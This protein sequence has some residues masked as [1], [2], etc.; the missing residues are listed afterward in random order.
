[1]PLVGGLPLRPDLRSCYHSSTIVEYLN[2]LCFQDQSK[3]LAYWYFDFNNFAQQD[4]ESMLRSLI[5]QLSAGVDSFPD[6]VRRLAQM[7]RRRGSHPKT[8]QLLLTFNSVVTSLKKDVFLVLDALDEFP[9]D[10]RSLKRSLLLSVIN[11]I[12]EAGHSNLH[13]LVTSRPESDIR[14]RL[15][16][17]SNPPQELNVESPLLVDLELF[18]DTTMELSPAL[19]SLGG[20]TK[21][22]IRNHLIT[23]EQR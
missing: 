3:I 2:D 17:L 9:E 23:G 11:D 7:H 13:L 21:N 22:R 6:A 8:T 14:G 20:D 18:F 19:K 1:M 16:S 12:V 5:R 15:R 4:V 10:A